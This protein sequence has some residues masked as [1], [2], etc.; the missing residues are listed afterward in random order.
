MQNLTSNITLLYSLLFFLAFL[1]G[2][3]WLVLLLFTN[4]LKKLTNSLSQKEELI[5][6]LEAQLL[7]CS[8]LASLGQ[9]S[10]E[11]AHDINNPLTIIKERAGLI[12]DI[13]NDENQ[14]NINEYDQIKDNASKIEQSVDRASKILLRTLNFARNKNIRNTNTNLQALIIEIISFLEK[15]IKTK[16]IEI[17]TH[18][19][20]DLYFN[21][22]DANKTEQII[23]NILD[24]ALDAVEEKG[25]IKIETS[26]N[27]ESYII[28]IIDNGNGISEE[29]LKLIFTPFFSTK[30]SAVKQDGGTGLGLFIANA[31]TTELGGT[32]KAENNLDGGARF[33]IFLPKIS[34]TNE[35]L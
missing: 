29:N 25:I 9:H 35:K 22:L 7:E 33:S 3:S 18:F 23:F 34:N 13:L 28:Q 21:E 10:A 30:N 14:N 12:K 17:Q 1:V 20:P 27:S 16:Q 2:I 32:L 26:H 6:K 15:K 19:E 24:N 4:K 8:K 31:L 11:L 5:K